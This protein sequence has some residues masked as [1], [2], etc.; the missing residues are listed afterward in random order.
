[1]KLPPLTKAV[2]DKLKIAFACDDISSGLA[3][4]ITTGLNDLVSNDRA[5]VISTNK[6]G[7]RNRYRIP[8]NDDGDSLIIDI[9]P[10][11]PQ[12]TYW[13]MVWEYNPSKLNKDQRIALMLLAKEILGTDYRRLLSNVCICELHVAV[14]FPVKISEVAIESRDKSASAVWG[15]TIDGRG[16]LQTLYF[17]SSTTDHH[18]TAYDKRD[19]V[20]AAL[21][22]KHRTTLSKLSASADGM[23]ERLRLEDRQRLSRCP[24]PLHRLDD[25]REPFAGFH[26]YTYEDAETHLHD[27]VGRLVLAVA[28]AQGLQ[29]AL[30]LL[31]KSSKETVRRALA[32]CQVDWW[33]AST[34]SRAVH[35]VLAATGLFPKDAFDA[36][37]REHT[38]LERRY[39]LRKAAAR[40]RGTAKPG[41]V[42]DLDD[43]ADG[44]DE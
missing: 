29:V 37:G 16:L 19:E 34:Y 22:R 13:R 26:I 4:E 21:V 6:K 12:R 39:Q 10:H 35:K 23:D 18:Q 3:E 2:A 15:K 41:R 30:K 27:Q 38:E 1:M 17:G 7:Y 33:Q 20:L 5:T 42:I 32:K 28:K 11:D 9:N 44:D 8:L 14:D 31:D 43:E 36:D 25:L 24:V 40:A